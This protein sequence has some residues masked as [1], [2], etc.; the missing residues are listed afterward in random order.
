MGV[1]G[2]IVNGKA[3]GLNG[4]GNVDKQTT[5]GGRGPENVNFGSEIGD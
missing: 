5:G 1:E 2:V 4:S 3:N